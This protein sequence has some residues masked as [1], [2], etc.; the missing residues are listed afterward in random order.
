M[1]KIEA[2]AIK[3]AIGADHSTYYSSKNESLSVI[4]YSFINHDYDAEKE[5]ERIISLLNLVSDIARPKYEIKRRTYQ[6]FIHN[7]NVIFR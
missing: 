2:K 7:T 4:V 1:K 5:K 6:G 3:K